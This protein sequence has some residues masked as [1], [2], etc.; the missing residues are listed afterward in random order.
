MN[1][2]ALDELVEQGYLTRSTLDHLS[3]YN[4]TDKATYDRHWVPET[5]NNRGAV[6]DSKTG[7]CVARPFPKFFNL[8]EHDSTRLATLP[9]DGFT[10]FEKL[11]GSLGI[12]FRHKGKLRVT[13]RGSLHSDQGA[14]ATE[15]LAKYNVEKTLGDR[16]T[17]LFE[18]IYPSNRIVVPYGEREDLVLIGAYDRVS[19][20]EMP[21]DWCVA[22]A[23][24]FG[25]PT[26]KVYQHSFDELQSQR[27]TMPYTD[28]GW[29]L[30]YP[31]G[32]RVKM[33][34]ADYLRIHKIISCMGPLAIWEAMMANRIGDYLTE[35]PEEMRA[36]AE[37]IYSALRSQFDALAG[38]ADRLTVDLALRSTNVKDG[39]ATKS[40]ALAIQK[41]A[42][43]HL[44]GYLFSVMRGK[45]DPTIL[46]KH[47]RPD[48][49]E[50][51]KPQP[52]S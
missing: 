13:T 1:F 39:A 28:E 21:W 30:R 48:G 20:D 14:K 8:D 44:R 22:A 29:V 45:E 36:E 15:M 11:D 17:L 31:N 5:L 46:L 32:L 2:K 10:A 50:M 19:G 24:T 51:K 16:I 37:E 26:A 42:P 33:K 35:I 7:E 47:I 27:A 12:L 49:N 3:L 4:Y 9:R 18:I 41:N 25:M 52:K 23:A 40:A 38:E 43:E 6:Y 34:G